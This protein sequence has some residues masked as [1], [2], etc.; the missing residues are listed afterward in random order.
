M[1]ERRKPFV[2]DEAKFATQK[3]VTYILLL[4]FSAV[5]ANVLLGEDQAERSTILQTIINLTILGVG[6][7]L[8]S[9][10]GAT[11][12]NAA[13]GKI[14]EASA[15]VAAAAVAAATATTPVVPAVL[16]T[17]EKQP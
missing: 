14:A 5:T 7:W 16:P 10:K 2:I 13:I 8:G 9:S 12:S 6:Y 1:K 4:L 17:E 15:P 3:L 11:D